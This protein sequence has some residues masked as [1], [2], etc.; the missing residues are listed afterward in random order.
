MR[1]YDLIWAR[2]RA[3]LTQKAAADKMGVSKIT[4]TRWELG[5]TNISNAKY[6]AFLAAVGISLAEVAAAEKT[7]KASREVSWGPYVYNKPH[8]NP[9]G[10]TDSMLAKFPKDWTDDE[11]AH[12]LRH[13]LKEAGSISE[14]DLLDTFAKRTGAHSEH[15]AR[16]EFTQLTEYNQAEGLLRLKKTP[17]VDD[18]EG[19]GLV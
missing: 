11:S 14:R 4:F 16:I 9:A 18:D 5:D 19:G 2:E 12:L 8:P 7:V 17:T 15:L 1:N 6:N 10:L 13:L 3:G